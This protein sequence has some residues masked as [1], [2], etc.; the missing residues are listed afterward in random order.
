MPGTPR[1]GDVDAEEKADIEIRGRRR[2]TPEPDGQMEEMGEDGRL[3]FQRLDAYIVAK[4]IVRRVHRMKIADRELRDQATRAAKSTFLRLSEGLANEGAAMRRKYFTE[5]N[6]SLHELLAAM[7]LVA[8]I[9][10]ARD[11]DAATVQHLGVR[12]KR[13]IRGLMH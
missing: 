7:D 9:G 5:A 11:A 10:V 6:N 1:E 2:G 3:P 12:L 8:T 13:M 4:E